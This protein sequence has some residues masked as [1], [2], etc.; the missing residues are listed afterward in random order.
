[1]VHDSSNTGLG[2][3]E[4]QTSRNGTFESKLT[5]AG[6]ESS[7]ET[8]GFSEDDGVSCPDE[9]WTEEF[10]HVVH[11]VTHHL[12]SSSKYVT[13]TFSTSNGWHWHLCIHFGGFGPENQTHI[14]AY[15][16]VAGDHP[17]YFV[18]RTRFKIDIQEP[19][20]NSLA[21]DVLSGKNQHH[22]CASVGDNAFNQDTKDYGHQYLISSRVFEER[23]VS[24]QDTATFVVH[25]S[26]E[27]PPELDSKKRTGMVGLL[28]QGATCYLNS[29][30]QALYHTRELRRAVFELDTSADVPEQ[31]VALELQRLFANLQTQS[32]AVSTQSLTKAFGWTDL[33]VFTQHDVQELLRELL[34]K[35]EER[36][37]GTSQANVI[38][39][40]FCGRMVTRVK[41]IKVE[42]ETSKLEDFFDLQLDVK[43]QKSVTESF[44]KYIEEERLDG[45]NQYEAEGFGKQD[46]VKEVKFE[47]FPPVLHLHLK[48]FAFDTRTWSPH[49]I[50]DRYEFSELLNLNEF[51]DS[52][53]DFSYLLH[54]VLVHSGN[55][56]RGHYYAFVNLMND[57]R[58]KGKWYKFNDEHV[59]RV[60]RTEAIRDTFGSSALEEGMEHE[61]KRRKLI[62]LSQASA[63]MLVYIRKNHWNSVMGQIQPVPEQILWRQEEDATRKREWEKERERLKHRATAKV[64]TLHD[65]QQFSAFSPLQER[66]ADDWVDWAQV[67]QIGFG[68]M[69]E[70]TFQDLYKA[71]ER[72]FSLAPHS[73]RLWSTCTRKNETIRMEKVWPDSIMASV[74]ASDFNGKVFLEELRETPVEK[75]DEIALIFREYDP[76]LPGIVP[77]TAFFV[78]GTGLILEKSTSKELW[79]VLARQVLHQSDVHYVA[80]QYE[81]FELVT[82]N[83]D[84]HEHVERIS[85]HNDKVLSCSD[86][87]KYLNLETA[88]DILIFSR[89]AKEE[90]VDCCDF[91][92][93]VM[94]SMTISCKRIGTCESFSVTVRGDGLVE[95]KLIPAIANKVHV[96]AARILL[97]LGTDQRMDL[98]PLSEADYSSSVKSLMRRTSEG[99]IFYFEELPMDREDLSQYRRLNFVVFIP[100]GFA[101]EAGSSRR[102]LPACV[103]RNDIA[104]ELNLF[105]PRLSNILALKQRLRNLNPSSSFL[106]L[107]IYQVYNR[108][109]DKIYRD[110]DPLEND[111][112]RHTIPCSNGVVQEVSHQYTMFA[113]FLPF[114]PSSH[115]KRLFK[116]AIQHCTMRGEDSIPREVGLPSIGHLKEEDT[117]GSFWERLMIRLNIKPNDRKG[118]RP[119]IGLDKGSKM[120]ALDKRHESC[121]GKSELRVLEPEYHTQPLWSLQ[122]VMDCAKNLQDGAYISPPT[123]SFYIW[124]SM[125]NVGSEYT[126][127]PTSLSIRS[128]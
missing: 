42:C 50:H 54:S 79:E 56:Q 91:F 128:S 61:L 52:D 93:N 120:L 4:V 113:E 119:F 112:E 51:I 41:C 107:V 89:K 101:R 47:Y 59:A 62:P 77:G 75:E 84:S 110:E 116:I 22:M 82:L 85:Y 32:R 24:S 28:N 6:L 97:T 78:S 26:P 117:L 121:Q 127:L 9:E 29:L 31:G 20:S 46:A 95:G 64:A 98:Y 94:K 103:T 19:G 86:D 39:E 96:D 69:R 49:K 14:S 88:G 35:L 13:E 43:G 87:A 81:L 27:A 23:F 40:L 72:H 37:K 66:E 108:R 115:G 7:E 118:W 123:L 38:K 25:V 3:G 100:L 36:M 111:A 70:A 5:G 71:C 104:E 11:D 60:K 106:E 63:Y 16:E 53:E 44:S 58:D 68:D 83:I 21:S 124:Q 73:F 18:R 45:E 34:D 67:E 126:A 12:R 90:E 8:L 114:V 74:Q 92:D 2:R 57:V 80:R 15:L 1:M 122:E 17:L 33:Q 48:R 10:K 65:L 105:L 55:D 99:K 109:L 76:S 125:T 102:A 30:L